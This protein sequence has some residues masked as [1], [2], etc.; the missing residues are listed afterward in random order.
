VVERYRGGRFPTALA[1]CVATDGSRHAGG[2]ITDFEVAVRKRAGRLADMVKEEVRD[3]H[4]R[5]VLRRQDRGRPGPLRQVDR[6][7]LER[8]ADSRKQA[9]LL[10][11]MNSRPNSARR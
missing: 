10:G 1:A 8:K 4:H 7:D 5:P 11:A 2:P 9:A 3:R 6:Q